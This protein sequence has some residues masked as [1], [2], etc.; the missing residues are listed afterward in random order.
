MNLRI[1][2]RKEKPD[3]H[4]AADADDAPLTV[5]GDVRIEGEAQFPTGL[6]T[7]GN[8]TVGQDARLVGCVRVA[9]ALVMHENARILGDVTVGGDATME[10]AARIEGHLSC[11]KLYLGELVHQLEPET[12]DTDV[13]TVAKA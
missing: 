3:A 10:T 13:A 5:T 4:E 6:V 11:R 7:T 1:L 8:L 2:R 12:V 9:G